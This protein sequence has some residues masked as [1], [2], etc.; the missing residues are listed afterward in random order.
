MAR[1]RVTARDLGRAVTLG[2]AVVLATT[3]GCGDDTTSTTSAETSGRA[4]APSSDP[5]D[6]YE[7]DVIAEAE[8]DEGPPPLTVQF[9][10][11][12]EEDDGGPW[13]FAWD[14]GDGTTSTEQNPSHTYDPVG[15]Y[16]A[17]LTATDRAGHTGTD[18]IDVFVD[19]DD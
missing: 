6:A 15:D 17:T 19:A 7:L 11:Y 10:G 8:P 14:F 9:R 13:R 4:V 12:V 5:V 2:L 3:V 18:E 16:T 1:V